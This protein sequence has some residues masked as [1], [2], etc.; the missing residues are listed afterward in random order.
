M[1]TPSAAISLNKLPSPSPSD[2]SAIGRLDDNINALSRVTAPWTRGQEIV[3][4]RWADNAKCYL[5]M[6]EQ[7]QAR[8]HIIDNITMGI[9]VLITGACSLANTIISAGA[10][11]GFT[12]SWIFGIVSIVQTGF[13]VGINKLGLGPRAMQHGQFAN[14]WRDLKFQL[15]AELAKPIAYR[16]DCNSFTNLVRKQMDQ[17]CSASD[18]LIPLIIRNSCR[19]E[20]NNIPNFDLPEICGD[21]EHT[22]AYTD[23]EI[24]YQPPIVSVK[25]D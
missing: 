7:A 20:F 19:T 23:D 2:E 9:A 8:F 14:N 15:E 10:V 13:M 5:W 25:K 21:L 12:N 18:A 6:H 1:T 17:I 24:I 22:Q 11:P 3:L 4:E 16:A